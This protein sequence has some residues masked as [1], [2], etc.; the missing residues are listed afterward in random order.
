MYTYA[1]I[2][3][4]IVHSYMD[5]VGNSKFPNVC[6]WMHF[7]ASDDYYYYTMF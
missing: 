2:Y 4:M 5:T 1:D 6:D 3:T 7:I